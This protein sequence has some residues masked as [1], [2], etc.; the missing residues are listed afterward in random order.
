[1]FYN[2]AGKPWLKLWHCGTVCSD[3]PASDDALERYPAAWNEFTARHGDP[4]AKQPPAT[5]LGLPIRGE[6]APTQV[7]NRPTRNDT[8]A[9][10][11]A[12]AELRKAQAAAKAA[13]PTPPWNPRGL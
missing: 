4:R 9:E 3:L 7:K 1:L 6:T 2:R 8:L 10:H 5:G 11:F 13:R 12:L